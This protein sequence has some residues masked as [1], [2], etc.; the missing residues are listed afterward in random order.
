MVAAGGRYI[1]YDESK[2][3][4]QI[5]RALLGRVFE[6]AKPHLGSVLIVLTTIVVVSLLGLIPALDLSRSD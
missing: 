5:D 4:A 2:G 3:K 6:Y 1:S